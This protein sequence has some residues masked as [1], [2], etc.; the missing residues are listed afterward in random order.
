MA[1]NLI[2]KLV[3]PVDFGD[4][5]SFS[6]VVMEDLKKVVIDYMS[7]VHGMDVEDSITIE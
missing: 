3:V 4:D 2:K 6:D 7:S 1:T 5:P